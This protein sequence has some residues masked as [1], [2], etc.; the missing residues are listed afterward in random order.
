MNTTSTGRNGLQLPRDPSV[1]VGPVGVV[2]VILKLVEL[3]AWLVIKVDDTA[4]VVSAA[5]V[6]NSSVVCWLPEAAV[7]GSVVADKSVADTV[8]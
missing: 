2:S 7:A 4:A 8:V 6:A 3:D 5:V 1:V